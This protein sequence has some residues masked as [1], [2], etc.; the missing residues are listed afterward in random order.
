MPEWTE[1]RILIL[2][3]TYP[4]YSQKYTENVCTGGVD[5][6]TGRL[7]RIH[8]VPR[9]YMDPKHHFKAFQWISA[10]VSQHPT[11]PRPESLRIDPA[12][13]EVGGE[14]PA[15]EASE[16]RRWLDRSPSFVSSVRELKERQHDDKTS[17]GILRPAAI[18]SVRVVP[19]SKAERE[20]WFK[21]EEEVLAQENLFGEKPKPLDFPALKFLI[22]WTCAD[23][24]CPAKHEMSLLEWGAH[25][26]A[27]KYRN[28]REREEKVL[29]ALRRRL[30]GEYEPYL[31]LGS[32]R[33]RLYNF[34][35]MGMYTPRKTSQTELSFGD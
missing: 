31:F 8:P 26:L 17:L 9:R 14:I 10:R 23:A 24:Q 15:K 4:S 33:G 19:R 13:I 16:R 12:S 21:K 29:E 20:E 27:R 3:M 35:L 5:A 22:A 6:E 32:F 25:E 30:T 28:P 2:G 18:H 34:G 1:K 7:V 11:D